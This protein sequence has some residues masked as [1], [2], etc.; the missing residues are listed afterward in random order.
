[1]FFFA[2]KLTNQ[3]K[4][5]N[6]KELNLDKPELIVAALCFFDDVVEYNEFSDP[7]CVVS[8]ELVFW[9]KNVTSC[10]RASH[11]LALKCCN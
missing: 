6:K 3:N 8:A 2:P 1:M 5:N 10:S 7:D 4:N 9:Y 11:P